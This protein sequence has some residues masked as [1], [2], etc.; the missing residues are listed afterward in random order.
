MY[1]QRIT[2]TTPN[3]KITA[4]SKLIID[5]FISNFYNCLQDNVNKSNLQIV[6]K[7]SPGKFYSNIA[8]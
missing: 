4:T 5:F 3:S 8:S 2:N 6:L 7:C 1:I